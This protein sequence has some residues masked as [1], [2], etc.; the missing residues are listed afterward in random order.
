LSRD[1]PDCVIS[2]Q[3]GDQWV[4]EA[5]S[6]VL[7]VLSITG[8]P[9]ELNYIINP[10]HPEARKLKKAKQHPVVWDERLVSRR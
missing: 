2:W 8:R 4:E 3:F 1:E 6:A 7:C 10:H 5:R 9:H